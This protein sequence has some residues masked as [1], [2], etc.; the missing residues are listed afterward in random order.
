MHIPLALRTPLL[1][2]LHCRL[3]IMLAG[4]GGVARHELAAAVC[5]AG[6]FG[7]LGMVREPVERVRHEIKSLREKTSLSFAVNLIPAATDKA[8]LQAQV[9][10]CLAQGV[11]SIVLFW[12]VDAPLIQHLKQEGVQVIHQVGSVAEAEQALAA[13]ADILI[14]QGVEA[15]GHVRGLTSTLALLP[16]VVEL[17]DVPVVASGG[18]ANGATLAAALAL[19]AQGASLGSAFLATT[20]ANAHP[21]HKQRVLEAGC[22]DTLLT[23]VFVGSWPQ[24]APVRVLPNAITQGQYQGDRTTVIARQ[25]DTDIYAYSTDSPLVGATGELELMAQYCGQSAAQINALVSV[26]E[27]IAEILQGVGQITD[28]WGAQSP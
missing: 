25:D 23:E 5:Q 16:P 1:K 4:M 6:G 18:I 2:K 17:S 20:E 10:E 13:G 7:V 3:P 11:K 9:A 27:R 21:H 28:H 24:G 19:G 8:L 14:A 15:G 12:T 26:H 22:D